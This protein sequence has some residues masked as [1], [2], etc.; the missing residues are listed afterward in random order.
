VQGQIKLRIRGRKFLKQQGD[1]G[2][3][4]TVNRIESLSMLRLVHLNQMRNHT[5]RLIMEG[6]DVLLV[7]EAVA[8]EEETEIEDKSKET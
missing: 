7:L 4:K 2:Y 3:L 6:N 1:K 5:W 8:W